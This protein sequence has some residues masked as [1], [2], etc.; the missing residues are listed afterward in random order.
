[1]I[2]SPKGSPVI[3][4]PAL[5]T[6]T[7]G[8]PKGSSLKSVAMREGSAAYSENLL[9]QLIADS[10]ALLP[11]KEFLPTTTSLISLGR[12]IVV[13]IGGKSGYI[14][15]LLITNEGRLVLVETKL[16]RNPES[17]REVIAQILQYGMALTALS[18]QE[19]EAKLPLSGH[20]SIREFAAS[21]TAPDDLIDDFEE[22]IEKHLRRGELLYLIVSDGIRHSVE[23]I[24]HWL[25]ENG[26]A[27]FKLGMVE[28]RF[29]D[30]GFGNMLVVPRTLLKTR[31]V[32]RHV[33]VVDVQGDGAANAMAMV[34]DVSKSVL[35]VHALTERSVKVAGL[36]MTLERLIAEVRASKGN[37]ETAT[38]ER[39]VQALEALN[40][41][42]RATATQFQFGIMSQADDGTFL[43]LLSLSSSGASSRPSQRLIEAVGDEEFVSHK[44]RMNEV[45]NFYRPEQALDATKKSNELIVA[46]DKLAGK[47][48]T[49]A[50]AVSR[51]MAVVKGALTGR[52]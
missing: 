7:D 22:A 47:E 12:E 23:R 43:Q 40:L 20:R 6:F 17:T 51:S 10:P 15:N 24:A 13:D 8:M 16:W 34:H 9:Q 39:I 29:F 46:W 49:L 32:S 14:D 44:L 31:E 18:L 42:T 5:V 28:L 36:P 26:S 19:L 37:T 50:Q 48:T 3:G 33:V 41:D 4:G 45:A 2:N 27:P 35:G 38:V 30:S 21:L 52:A 11:V 25:N 1:M